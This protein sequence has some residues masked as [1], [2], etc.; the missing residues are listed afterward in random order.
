MRKGQLGLSLKTAIFWMALIGFFGVM[1]AKLF[2]AYVEYYT[3]KKMLRQ[4]DEAGDLKGTGRDIR[5]SFDK[6]NAIED[7]KN[8]RPHDLEITK[9]GG[10]AGGSG[11]PSLRI[12]LGADV[13]PCPDVAAPTA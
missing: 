12:P 7:A 10:E 8:V 13:S 2:P 11:N 1:G 9:E 4:M 3:V 6:R 5:N